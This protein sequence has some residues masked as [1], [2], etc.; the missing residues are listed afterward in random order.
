MKYD[1]ASI[2]EN[3]NDNREGSEVGKI[4]R[5][6]RDTG[7]SLHCK[8][9]IIIYVQNHQVALIKKKE[10]S[11]D[12]SKYDEILFYMETY[13]E[14]YLK[15]SLPI[16]I[17][18]KQST[19]LQTQ[20]AIKNC[21]ILF[22]EKSSLKLFS[23]MD[24]FLNPTKANC[25]IQNCNYIRNFWECWSIEFIK[26]CELHDEEHLIGFLISQNFNAPHFFTYLTN[27]ITSELNNED[28][29]TNQKIVLER[30]LRKYNMVLPC[31]NKEY[32]VG[33]PNIRELVTN[34]VSREI[35][36]CKKRQKQF[37][38]DQT[39]L[40][41]N[42]PGSIQKIETS[43]SVPQLACL[44]KMLSKSGIVTNPVKT[45]MLEAVS[46]SFKTK[47]TETIALE[48]LHNKFYNMED[49]TRES[50]KQLLKQVILEID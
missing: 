25:T 41:G 38:P 16:S 21:K 10:V 13:F 7:Y 46:K 33:F 28:D 14:E 34:W 9:E 47:K 11:F 20:D 19:I 4:I 3:I 44:F 42:D 32:K 22:S 27:E 2:D 49:K 26:F 17:L 40:L 36:Y 35:K 39:T 43:L 6:I 24:E 37:N 29:P 45:E 1:L 50:V 31:N 30:Y 5:K 15:G 23:L 12:P 48:S 8:E 18:G